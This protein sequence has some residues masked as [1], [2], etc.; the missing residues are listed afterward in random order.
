[1]LNFDWHLF[2]RQS[3]SI[4]FG[5]FGESSDFYLLSGFGIQHPWS[6]W[7]WF[8]SQMSCCWSDYW[9]GCWSSC[10]GRELAR[11]S[12]ANY[13]T[14]PTRSTLYCCCQPNMFNISNFLLVLFLSKSCRWIKQPWQKISG[15]NPIDQNVLSRTFSMPFLHHVDAESTH[16]VDFNFRKVSFS[17]FL[18]EFKNEVGDKPKCC[19]L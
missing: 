9:L 16:I 6:L 8:G 4:W 17:W 13:S 10:Y 2:A 3:S 7:V 15:H 18:G 19:V 12:A 14:S 1:M 11:I 5:D